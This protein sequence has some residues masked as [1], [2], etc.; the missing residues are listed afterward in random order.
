MVN[1]L[2]N[3]SPGSEKTQTEMQEVQV[4]LYRFKS[5]PKHGTILVRKAFSKNC[6]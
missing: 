5:M 1:K 3:I 6:A 4:G 2:R